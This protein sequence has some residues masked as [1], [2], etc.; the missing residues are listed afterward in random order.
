MPPQNN[1]KQHL[2]WLLTAKPFI[3]PSIPLVAYSPDENTNFDDVAY[4]Q[5]LLD[6]IATN[7]EPIAAAQ[8]ATAPAPAV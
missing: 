2:K 8:P 5:S 4:E 3:P 1:F 7:H 6:D